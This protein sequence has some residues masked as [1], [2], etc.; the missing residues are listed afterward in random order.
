MVSEIGRHSMPDKGVDP[1][2]RG[3]MRASSGM[4]R[5]EAIVESIKYINADNR[6]EYMMGFED[7]QGDRSRQMPD[8]KKYTAWYDVDSEG[9]TAQDVLAIKRKMMEQ[10][11]AQ[12]DRDIIGRKS[13][14]AS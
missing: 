3:Y 14:W 7:G 4:L 6:D 5:S 12:I 1:Y 11:K 2:E 9:Y 8:L 13:T 10:M